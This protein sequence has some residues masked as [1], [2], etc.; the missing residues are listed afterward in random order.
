MNEKVQGICYIERKGLVGYSLRKVFKNVR[1][2]AVVA[3]STNLTPFG[4]P[5]SQ[6]YSRIMTRPVG[7][8]KGVSKSRR[9]G[10]VGSK[11]FQNLAGRVGS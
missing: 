10:R 9:S 11:G 2:L 5:K 3:S 6:G 7:R 4:A 1:Q 8:V